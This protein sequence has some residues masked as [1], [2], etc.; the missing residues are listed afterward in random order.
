MK[1]SEFTA[2]GLR[3]WVWFTWVVLVASLGAAMLVVLRPAHAQQVA[4]GIWYLAGGSHHSVLVEFADH[5]TL[6]EAPFSQ[7]E[8][9]LRARVEVRG[10]DAAVDLEIELHDG[11]EALQERL[12]VD[13]EEHRAVLDRRVDV[14][15]QVGG[16]ERRAAAAWPR[17]RPACPCR[18]AA[19]H[20]RR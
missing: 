12:L 5:L 14:G 2:A 11:P 16:G 15:V 19:R 20:R 6:I 1:T 13:A 3:S 4:P 9:E 7:M 10:R 8:H 17:R 18:K